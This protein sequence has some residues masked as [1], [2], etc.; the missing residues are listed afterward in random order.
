MKPGIA[1]S[2]R[3]PPSP[4]GDRSRTT[5]VW[6]HGGRR[7]PS[8]SRAGALRRTQPSPRRQGRSWAVGGRKHGLIRAGAL[9]WRWVTDTVGSCL[10]AA[11]GQ[12]GSCLSASV[13]HHTMCPAVQ[14]RGCA[15]PVWQPKPTRGSGSPAP[16]SSY[17]RDRHAR[18]AAEPPRCRPP[19][20]PA[21]HGDEARRP[22]FPWGTD[23][24]PHPDAAG[25]DPKRPGAPKRLLAQCAGKSAAFISDGK[26]DE[27]GERCLLYHLM[28]LLLMEG[29]AERLAG[30]RELPWGKACGLFPAQHRCRMLPPRRAET[31]TPTVA[32]PQVAL[33]PYRGRRGFGRVCSP[34][35]IWGE[36]GLGYL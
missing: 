18:G 23:R 31:R 35:G 19:S 10:Q 26:K 7:G 34:G 13:A 17:R 29:A 8:G 27:G 25:P 1:A 21:A 9:K 15:W 24:R 32:A 22:R 30:F 11:R 28:T 12:G 6:S 2:A 20:P 33:W 5:G 14:V 3:S 16:V 4:R 36:G